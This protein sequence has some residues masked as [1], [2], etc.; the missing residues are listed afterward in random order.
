MLRIHVFDAI[1]DQVIA[2]VQDGHDPGLQI[3]CPR[4]VRGVGMQ[5]QNTRMRGAAVG[6][7]VNGHGGQ[8]QSEKNESGDAFHCLRVA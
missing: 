2:G 1:I 4:E 7:R 3:A 6:C 8:G 5:D